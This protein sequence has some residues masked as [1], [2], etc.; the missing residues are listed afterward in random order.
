QAAANLS[1]KRDK[2]PGRVLTNKRDI[3]DVSENGLP[4]LQQTA[5]TRRPAARHPEKCTAACFQIRQASDRF[6]A[7]GAISGEI[8]TIFSPEFGY[9]CLLLVPKI[10]L[11]G[12]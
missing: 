5:G 6:S 1:N 9:F 12:I 11:Y 10:G 3:S 7:N 4:V 8:F 2:L